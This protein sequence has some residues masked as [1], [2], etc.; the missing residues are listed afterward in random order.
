MAIVYVW[1]LNN[2][3][4]VVN[5]MFGFRFPALYLPA[6][7]GLLEFLMIGDLWG[8]LVGILVGHTYY[9][10]S[11]IYSK[12]DPRWRTRLQAPGWLQALVPAVRSISLAG[13]Y[14]G[15][16]VQRPEEAFGGRANAKAPVATAATGAVPS[17]HESSFRAFAGKGH[18]L[19][20]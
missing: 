14:Q 15:F 4:V 8:P 7:L 10:L 17:A 3:E 2:R 5:F 11:E 16:S 9:F 6:V 1:A 18:K 20:T 19:G 12:R 13:G